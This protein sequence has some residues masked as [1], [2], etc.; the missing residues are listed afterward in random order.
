MLSRFK[1]VREWKR[2]SAFSSKNNNPEL[3]GK[4][5]KKIK[6]NNYDQAEH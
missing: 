6:F 1:D 3:G 5:T 2:C 4:P